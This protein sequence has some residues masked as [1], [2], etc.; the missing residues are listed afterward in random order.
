MADGLAA[1]RGDVLDESIT[2]AVDDPRP[3]GL[4]WDGLANALREA[5][6]G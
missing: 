6:A 3:D 5:L 1:R 4:G 2:R